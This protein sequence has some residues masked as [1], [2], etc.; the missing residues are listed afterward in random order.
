MQPF[1]GQQSFAGQSMQPFAGQSPILLPSHMTIFIPGARVKKLEKKTAPVLLLQVNRTQKISS[2]FKLF[3]Y[4]VV[5][6]FDHF[7]PI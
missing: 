5:V 7:Q 2:E 4:F 6:K 1:S 3:W